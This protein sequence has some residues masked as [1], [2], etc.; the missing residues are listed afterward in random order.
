MFK[1]RTVVC[2]SEHPIN[3]PTTIWDVG[4]NLTGKHMP[5][6]PLALTG[7]SGVGNTI[8][9]KNITSHFCIYFFLKNQ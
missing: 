4:R 9:N 7:L 3:R 1:C 2:P 6:N 5:H 8:S